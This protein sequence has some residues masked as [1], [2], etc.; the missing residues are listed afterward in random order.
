M[1][2]L[3][4]FLLL[5]AANM[6]KQTSDQSD[7]SAVGGFPV[8]ACAPG[9]PAAA[10]GI[11][12]GD[13]LLEVNGRRLSTLSSDEVERELD[14]GIVRLTLRRGREQVELVLAL[15]TPSSPPVNTPGTLRA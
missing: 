10:S 4:Q 9:S 3:A 1:S 13:V 5:L 15:D 12:A 8:V 2:Q 7:K 11:R 6:R 14:R